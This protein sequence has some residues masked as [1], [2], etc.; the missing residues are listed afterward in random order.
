MNQ[1]KVIRRNLK[2]RRT[3]VPRLRRESM[4]TPRSF[5]SLFAMLSG[6][7]ER[8]QQARPRRRSA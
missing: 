6:A 2:V 3:P 5:A 4:A 8:L 1:Q 7:S